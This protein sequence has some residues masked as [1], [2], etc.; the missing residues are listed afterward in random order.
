MASRNK[1]IVE[2]VNAAFAANNLEGFLAHCAEDLIWTMVGDKTNKGKASIREWMKSAGE[3]NP[4]VFDV[5]DLIAE[6][7]IVMAQGNMTMADK[8]GT[9]VPYAYC[10]IY[11]FRGDRIV[12]LKSFV[13]KTEPA[14]AA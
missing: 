2:Q 14:A 1:G 3:M 12:E 13:V 8:D 9:V 10:D 5:A 11:R 6:G 7:H 4:P